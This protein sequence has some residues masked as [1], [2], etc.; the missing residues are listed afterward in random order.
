MKISDADGGLAGL[1]VVVS[2]AAAG[3][4]L[5]VDASRIAVGV[6]DAVELTVSRDATIELSDSPTGSGTF[7]SLFQKNLVAL[8]A[9]MHVNWSVFGPEDSNGQ[10]AVVALTGATYA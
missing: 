10:A 1:P 4:V 9:E 8:R 3:S 6:D 5:L 7:T 2:N